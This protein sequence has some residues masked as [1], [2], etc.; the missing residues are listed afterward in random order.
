MEKRLLLPS[1]T[2]LSLALS[3]VLIF[4]ARGQSTAPAPNSAQWHYERALVLSI[5]EQDRAKAELRRAIALQPGFPEAHYLL[6]IISLKEES[7]DAAIAELRDAIKQ[8]A[9]PH[10][11]A[12]VA[13]VRA[14][15]KKGISS[16]AVTELERVF[17]ILKITDEYTVAKLN[18]IKQS[19]ADQKRQP[20]PEVIQ[21]A[22]YNLIDA[23]DNMIKDSPSVFKQATVD[24]G[25]RDP[26][27]IF[28]LALLYQED[29]QYDAMS[30]LLKTAIEARGDFF[31]VAYLGLGQVYEQ[32]KSYGEAIAAYEAAADQLRRLGFEEGK[33]F[34]TDKIQ[35]LKLKLK[36]QD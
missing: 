31:P 35:E 34:D 22:I 33:D 2:L 8:S 32:K 6:G 25:L 26:A 29:G 12:Q 23:I 17:E 11:P 36:P 9:V 16:E 13:L 21:R 27:V 20:K 30:N 1:A 14:L 3:S 4:S 18:Q 7:F 24:A 28:E 19:N 5:E 15:N 10:L